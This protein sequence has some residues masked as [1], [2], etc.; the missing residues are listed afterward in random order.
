MK[1]IYCFF[2]LALALGFTACSESDSFQ[3]TDDA[4]LNSIKDLYGAEVASLSIQ[5]VNEIPSV[6]LVEAQC[7]LEAL[8]KNSNRCN[9]CVVED[10]SGKY[11]GSDGEVVKMVIMGNEYQAVTGTGALL[12]TFLIRVE[13]NFS[14]EE[15]KV[16]YLGTD[17]KYNS[18][19]FNW[20]A[21][22]LSLTPAKNGEKYTYEFESESFV[23]FKVA[24]EANCIIKVP[25]VFKG[26]YN[27]KSGQGTYSFQLTK[28]NK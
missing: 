7:V 22:G 28:Y 20:R 13:L 9:D 3:S 24:D 5:G 19:L 27:F 21:N 15:G 4:S 11:F 8:R 16:Y 10:Q 2:L 23:Y 26:N 12:E 25:I 6:T 18:D 1:A 14:M 17:Y